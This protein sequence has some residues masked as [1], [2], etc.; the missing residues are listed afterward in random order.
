[1]TVIV[2]RPSIRCV[3]GSERPTRGFMRQCN[4][5]RN[6]PAFRHGEAQGRTWGEAFDK[7]EIAMGRK[8][9]FT[10]ELPEVSD[11]ETPAASQV[12]Q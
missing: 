3:S 2:M 10:E 12:K 8:A 1:M 7:L 9:R 4:S 5:Y 11:T 6:P